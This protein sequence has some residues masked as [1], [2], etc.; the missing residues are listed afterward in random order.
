MK[1]LVV[2]DEM[3]SR[4]KL[5]L[6]MEN[7]GEC[8]A[9]DN[10]KDAVARFQKAHQQGKPFGLI[11]L[12][13][14]MPEMD[15]L[16]ALSEIVTAEIKLEVSKKHKAKILMVTSF[17]DKNRVIRCIQSGCDDYIAKPFD[18][19]T[20]GKKLSKLGIRLRNIQPAKRVPK[21]SDT[22]NNAHFI[23]SIITAFEEK[24]IT[25]PTL[26]RIHAKFRELIVT[27]A[28][29]QRI[30]DLL[31]KDVAIAA[32]LIRM[33][34]SAYYKGVM[35]NKSLAQAI[36]RLYAAATEKAVAELSGREFVT[37]KT[38]KYRTLIEKI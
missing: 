10:G 17:T 21:T 29:S 2:D 22:N 30:A 8:E 23:D 32:E 28:V 3:V 13:I 20:I 34:N 33:S 7:F 31:K 27:G 25:L 1:I 12:D 15:G 11:M 6:I 35:K 14:D 5:K 36:S 24:K 38:R 26:P 16:Q 37:M 18:V 9:V 4:T 19:N